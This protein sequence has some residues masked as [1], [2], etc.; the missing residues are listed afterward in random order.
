MPS[1][2]RL[3]TNSAWTSN[4]SLAANDTELRQN[5]IKLEQQKDELKVK[6]AVNRGRATRTEINTLKLKS[7]QAK[8]NET[9]LARKEGEKKKLLVEIG[10]GIEKV[11][12]QIDGQK[13]L[14]TSICLLSDQF[15]H[16][17]SKA[18]G[19]IESNAETLLSIGRKI[20]TTR[21]AM[22][23]KKQTH[24]HEM[25][26][27]QKEHCVLVKVRFIFTK[28]MSEMRFLHPILHNTVQE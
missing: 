15:L 12:N 18:V 24:V 9:D 17:T 5:Q 6:D 28:S 3:T 25:Y 19:G 26:R 2:E 23:R 13:S 27:L 22:E 14:K 4:G 16:G 8:T 10:N 20:S 7:K 1:K 21:D 11:M